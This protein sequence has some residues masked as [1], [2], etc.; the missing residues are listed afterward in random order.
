[1]VINTNTKNRKNMFGGVKAL[2]L[3]HAKGSFFW[4]EKPPYLANVDPPN[5]FL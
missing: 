5:I 1:M 2:W 3:R 4:A